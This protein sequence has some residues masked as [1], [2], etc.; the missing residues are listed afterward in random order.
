MEKK[1]STQIPARDT[2]AGRPYMQGTACLPQ[3]V[4]VCQSHAAAH[5]EREIP[6][7][8]SGALASTEPACQCRDSHGTRCTYLQW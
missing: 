8:E 5:G 7:L 1:T 3:P 2:A 4:L 6:A